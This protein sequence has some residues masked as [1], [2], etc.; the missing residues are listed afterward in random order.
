MGNIEKKL[1]AFS[2]AALIASTASAQTVPASATN[3]GQTNALSQSAQFQRLYSGL[4]AAIPNPPPAV[5]TLG[6]GMTPAGGEVAP[7]NGTTGAIVPTATT[8]VGQQPR[9]DPAIL[10]RLYSGLTAAV[11][12]IPTLNQ[13]SMVP[14]LPPAT[15]LQNNGTTNTGSAS[16]IGQTINVAPQVQRLYSG[17]LATQPQF[18]TVGTVGAGLPP[19][20]PGTLPQAAAPSGLGGVPV[21]TPFTPVINPANVTPSSPIGPG[22]P[23]ATGT[24]F[25]GTINPA[26]RAGTVVPGRT[27]NP[28][29]PGG[30]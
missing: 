20:V 30:R 14:G 10:Q 19:A 22:V 29:N 2:F 25:P 18:P 6:P 26:M 13:T 28:S 11:P 21:R 12:T 17:L 8:S 27:V 23:G 7:N 4:T 3:A 16:L 5:G 15:N 9:I 1:L 24:T